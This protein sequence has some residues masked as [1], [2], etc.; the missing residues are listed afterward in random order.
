MTFTTPPRFAAW[1]HRDAREGFEVS[2]FHRTAD[3]GH[4]IEG[5]TTAVEAGEAWSVKYRIELDGAWRTRRA[6]AW[7]L[8][9][10]GPREVT[11]EADGAGHWHVDGA[12]APHLDGCFDVDF[13]SSSLTNAFP[14]R[15]LGLA[16]GRGAAAPAAYVHALDL[17][18][19][20]L[21]QHYA[22]VP[23]EAGRTRYDYESP[24][25]DFACRL[26]YDE[27]GL[28]LEYPG[29]AVRVA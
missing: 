14:A 20:R 11:L 26:V 8:S 9:S 22:R 6:R 16:V 19:T 28:V 27:F 3:G 4:R 12:P 2:F 7:G 13:E 24:T 29:I 15:R 5:H 1:R 23:D 17:G 21:E 10:S 25:F 18:V